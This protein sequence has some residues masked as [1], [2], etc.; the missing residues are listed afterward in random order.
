MARTFC[1]LIFF[2]ALAGR[3]AAGDAPASADQSG[4]PPLLLGALGKIAKNFDRWAFTEIR[5]TMDD[6]GVVKKE[7]ILRFDPSKPY[8]EQYRPLKIDGKPPTEKQLKN[9]RERGE[10]RAKKFAQQE[11][12][13]K[14]PGSELPKFEMNGGTASIDLTHATI[15]NE[16][17]ESV[18]YEV[19]LHND[20]KGTL[21]VE[22][23]Q[24]FAR[25]N[26]AS[27]SF[28]NVALRVRS[29]FRMKFVVKVKSGEASVEFATV[30]SAHDPLP[31]KMSG[32][33]TATILFLKFGGGFEVMRK[34]FA[35]VKPYGDRFG[36][37]I[38]PIKALDF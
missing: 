6:K 28:E 9:F 4:V 31:V 15:A 33:G 21:P 32:D 22:K 18:T 12:E 37:K 38:G 19:P 7:T 3:V 29:A 23:F 17:P 2:I 27:G 36:V 14:T 26:R 13:G 16:T 5:Q 11:A 24:L 35:R 1:V 8:A 34:D 10:K 20:G 30:D 25:V